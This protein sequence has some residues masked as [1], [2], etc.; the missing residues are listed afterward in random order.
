MT[1]RTPEAYQR[2]C[3]A[4]ERLGVSF[5]ELAEMLGYTRQ[6]ATLWHR[7]GTAP[8]VAGYAADALERPVEPVAPIQ[9]PKPPKRETAAQRATRLAQQR[10]EVLSIRERVAKG[11]PL[12][13]IADSIGTTYHRVRRIAETVHAPNR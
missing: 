10:V 11:V 3:A 2:L 1:T 4:R 13:V 12:Q 6:A 7:D 9:E 8:I 5:S